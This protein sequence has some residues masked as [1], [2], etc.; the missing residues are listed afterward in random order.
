M[1]AAGALL[2]A[3]ND[4]DQLSTGGTATESQKEENVKLNP[5]LATAAVNSLPNQ[6]NSFMY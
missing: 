4:L 3:C 5:E 2:A 1:V 6:V